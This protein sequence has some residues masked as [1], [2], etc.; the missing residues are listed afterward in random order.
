MILKDQASKLREMMNGDKK[1]QQESCIPVAILSCGKEDGPEFASMITKHVMEKEKKNVLFVN[2]QT[3]QTDIQSLVEHPF[4]YEHVESQLHLNWNAIEDN[5]AK[6]EDMIQN[7]IIDKEYIKMLEK[8]ED[9]K[10]VLAYYC[11]NSINAKAMN[12]MALSSS[13]FLI[14]E[15]LE[16][17][18]EMALQVL[19]IQ[20]EIQFHTTFYLVGK[21]MNQQT[22]EKI[23]CRL[24]KEGS[25]EIE[26]NIEGIGMIVSENIKQGDI[27]EVKWE[28]IDIPYEFIG[29]SLSNRL[30]GMK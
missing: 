26:T 6:I 11:G 18:I 20:R 30:L 7:K 13:I 19:K 24:Q 23:V 3:A 15:E 22:L 2:T 16:S 12:L 29:K 5:F 27:Q 21:N 25:N 4:L 1:R 28:K 14:V 17:S 10:E 9:H 8:I